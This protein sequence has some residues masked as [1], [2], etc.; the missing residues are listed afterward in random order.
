[1]ADCGGGKARMLINERPGGNAIGKPRLLIV[2]LIIQFILILFSGCL[3]VDEDNDYSPGDTPDQP[4]SENGNKIDDDRPSALNEEIFNFLTD[5]EVLS[6]SDTV[7]SGYPGLYYF[8]PEGLYSYLGSQY[9][10]REEGQ[11]LSQRGEWSL[12]DNTLLLT[13]LEEKRTY[14]GEPTHD[15]LLGDILTDYQV[16]HSKDSYQLIIMVSVNEDDTGRSYLVWNEQPV[17]MLFIPEEDI[18]P[19]RLLAEEGYEALESLQQ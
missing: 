1:V 5:G 3:P 15:L 7:G 19:L 6:H 14:G 9:G 2:F 18:V 10:I 8:S 13:I 4:I 11:L 17:Y 16:I 12:I